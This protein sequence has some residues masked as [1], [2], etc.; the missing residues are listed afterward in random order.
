MQS[1]NKAFSSFAQWVSRWSGRTPTF[2]LAIVVVLV[3]G[4]TGPLFHYSDTW[5]LVINTATTIFTFLMVFLIQN[6]QN[7]DS[8]ALQV[9]LSELIIAMKGA[10][11]RIASV[12][13]LSEE[14]L[15]KLHKEVSARAQTTSDVLSMRRGKKN[16][17]R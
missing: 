12:E 8:L 1:I 14:D 4:A 9:K 10:E 7:R 17:A 2:I 5:Q 11:N 3:W 6:T 15:E 16:Q 13:E